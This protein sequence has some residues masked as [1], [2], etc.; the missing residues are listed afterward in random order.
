MVRSDVLMI[1]EFNEYLFKI[2]KPNLYERVIK[3]VN[4]AFNG[5]NVKHFERT[6]YWLEKFYPKFTGA[7]RIAAYSHDI[8]RGIMKERDRDYLNKEFIIQHMNDGARIMGEFLKKEGA[9]NKTVEKVK[10]LIQAH[11][12]GG[13]EEQNA[14][15]DADSVSYFE[16]NAEMFVRYRVKKDGYE[17]VKGKLD[18]MFNR[19]STAEH[20][21]FA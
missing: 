12:I 19:I 10:H 14:L 3:F 7:H 18:W 2:M 4:T 15:M 20:K 1:S 21:N 17:K 13:D 11:E 16:T 6:V 5:K 8:E 9:D